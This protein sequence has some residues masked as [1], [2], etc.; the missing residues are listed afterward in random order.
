MVLEELCVAGDQ[1]NSGFLGFVETTLNCVSLISP[2]FW[3]A[4]YVMVVLWGP[5]GAGIKPGWGLRLEGLRYIGMNSTPE[6]FLPPVTIM[7]K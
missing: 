5:H 2:P 3:G 4:Q 7:H 6:N 1:T